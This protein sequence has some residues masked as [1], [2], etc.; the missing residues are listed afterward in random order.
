MRVIVEGVKDGKSCRHTFELVDFFDPEKNHTAMART[1]GFPAT[2]TAR[3]IANGELRERGVFFPE[4]IFIGSRFETM[5][6]ALSDKG[7]RVTYTE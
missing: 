2:I 1:T 3:M 7:V 5:T 6:A 4:Q